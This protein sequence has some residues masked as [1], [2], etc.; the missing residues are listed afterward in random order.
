MVT[1]YFVRRRGERLYRICLLFRKISRKGKKGNGKGKMQEKDIRNQKR[2]PL[3]F[4]S[5]AKGPR[6]RDRRW[7]REKKERK[8]SFY[9]RKS[10]SGEKGEEEIPLSSLLILIAGSDCGSVGASKPKWP[11]LEFSFFM[12][13]WERWGRSFWIRECKKGGEYLKYEQEE[14]RKGPQVKEKRKITHS[15][16]D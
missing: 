8:K 12:C 5:S 9:I 2:P 7:K 15:R 13:T 4:L 11:G 3:L 10:R 16:F 1:R 14:G 6:G